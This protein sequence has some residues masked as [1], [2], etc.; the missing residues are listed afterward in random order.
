M[1]ASINEPTKDMVNKELM[2]FKRFQVDV[3]DIKCPLEWWAKHKSFFSIVAIVARQI[4]GI[5][6]FQVETKITFSLVGVFT[7]LRRCCLQLDNSN[8][9]I[10][11]DKN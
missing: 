6:G 3:K 5:I 10:F 7:N 8:K 1:S 9:I 4:L 11:V 2:M